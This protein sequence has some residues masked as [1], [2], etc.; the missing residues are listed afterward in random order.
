[1]TGVGKEANSGWRGG[2]NNE[3]IQAALKM[4]ED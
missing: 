3:G 4:T 2:G 1:M